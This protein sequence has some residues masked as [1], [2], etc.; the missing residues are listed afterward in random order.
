MNGIASGM[1]SP[2]RFRNSPQRA[3]KLPVVAFLDPKLGVV[4]DPLVE[5]VAELPRPEQVAL[6]LMAMVSRAE[7]RLSG[8]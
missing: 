7:T 6:R 3:A 5:V 1:P 4:A 2:E 8:A